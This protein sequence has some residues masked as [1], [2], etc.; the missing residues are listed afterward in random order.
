MG[1]FGQI[2][3][4]GNKKCVVVLYL[5]V[6]SRHQNIFKTL[7]WSTLIFLHLAN[8]SAL[9]ASKHQLIKSQ[10][11]EKF[12]FILHESI[13]PTRGSSFVEAGIAPFLACELVGLLKHSWLVLI[14]AC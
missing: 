9:R 14:C 7:T 2:L 8:L 13:E 10:L 6:K 12:W 11:K 3:N 4:K 5:I 1:I